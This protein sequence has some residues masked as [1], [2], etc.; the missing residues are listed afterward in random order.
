MKVWILQT[1]EPLHIDEGNIRPMRAMNLSNKL[2]EAGHSVVLW[3]SAFNHQTKKHRVQKYSTYH[4]NEKLEI[5]L[6]P[7]F[8]YNKHIGFARLVDHIQLALNLKKMLKKEK[9]IPDVV[10]I[11]YPPIETAAILSK[12]LKIRNIPMVLDV[13]DLW[14]QMFIDKFPSFLKPIG[15]L[16]FFPYFYLAKRTIRDVDCVSAM[17]PSFLTSVLSFADKEEKELDRVLRLT[18][19]IGQSSPE[20]LLQA[21]IWWKEKGQDG[22]TPI[23]FFVGTFMSVFDFKPVYKAIKEIR[24]QGIK[25]NFV[26]CGSGDYLDNIK[27]MMQEFPNVFFPGWIERPKIESLAMISIASIAPYNNIDNYTLNTPNKIVDALALGLPIL[28]PLEGEIASLIQNHNVGITYNK[29]NPLEECIVKIMTNKKLQ[30]EM[31]Q[32][33]RNLYYQNFEF[34]KVY[35]DFVKHLETLANRR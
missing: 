9:E 26:L 14:P 6:I 1:G 28:C 16:I 17:A 18:T 4:V 21:K 29:I 27:T 8:G 34:N 32:N 23:I 15:R 10:F 24:G 25:C 31:A 3:S 13:K 33:A 22:S 2:I 7:S 5:R 19:P 35:D 11:G 30:K 20:E 12:W